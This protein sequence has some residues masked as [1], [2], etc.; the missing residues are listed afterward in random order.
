MLR[1]KCRSLLTGHHLRVSAPITVLVLAVAALAGA[2]CADGSSSRACG[3]SAHISGTDLDTAGLQTLKCFAHDL[4]SGNQQRLMAQES[5]PF[6]G[7]PVPSQVL[8]SARTGA[9]QIV[10]APIGDAFSW[11]PFTVKFLDGRKWSA[12][13]VGGADGAPDSWGVGWGA[14]NGPQVPTSGPG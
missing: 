6:I 9:F 7:N 13:L 3:S 14:A 11:R 5:A 4:Q 12:V 10:L 2:G 1:R 8:N